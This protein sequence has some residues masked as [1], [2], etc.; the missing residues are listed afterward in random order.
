MR[1]TILVVL[2]ASPLVLVQ[3]AAPEAAFDPTC[4]RWRATPLQ[5]AWVEA[6]RLSLRVNEAAPQSFADRFCAIGHI[7]FGP[8]G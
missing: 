2:D 1:G 5:N 7:E 8:K 4:G 3:L 6:M